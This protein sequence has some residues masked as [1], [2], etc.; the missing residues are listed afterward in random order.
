MAGSAELVDLVMGFLGVF[1]GFSD[2]ILRNSGKIFRPFFGIFVPR[3]GCIRCTSHA[4][5]TPRVSKL[6]AKRPPRRRRQQ[7]RPQSLS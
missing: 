5:D 1:M 2:H 6:S 3:P 4:E 7:P